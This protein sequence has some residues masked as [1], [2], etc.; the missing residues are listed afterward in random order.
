MYQ[1][2][3]DNKNSSHFLANLVSSFSCLFTTAPTIQSACE[4]ND[5]LQLQEL[6][7]NMTN[8]ELN[9]CDNNGMT[10]LHLCV[11]SDSLTCA[12]YLLHVKKVN[13]NIKSKDG[14]LNATAL[15]IASNRRNI[16]MIKLLLTHGATSNITDKRGHTPFSENK[17]L[18][19]LINEVNSSKE[20]SASLNSI[21]PVHPSH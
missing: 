12:E 3:K 14:Y 9:L 10:P 6:I 20:N 4:K 13:P 8:S 7:T 5:L 21:H 11:L 17:D 2:L 16:D 15:H 1:Q 18:I 19:Y